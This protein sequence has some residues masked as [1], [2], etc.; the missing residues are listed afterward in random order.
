MSDI[1][2][3]PARALSRRNVASRIAFYYAA[4]FAA[5]GIY[6]PYWGPWLQSNGIAPSEITLL[7]AV[8]TGM[9]LFAN[10]LSGRFADL[11][12]YRKATVVVL[13]FATMIAFF[14][15]GFVEGFL[16]IFIVTVISSIPWGPLVPL[17]DNLALL[18]VRQ[19]GMDY[20]RVRIWGSVAFIVAA[21]AMGGVLKF[22]PDTVIFYGMMVTF[23][24]AS[25]ASV[26]LPNTKARGEPPVREGLLRSLI[27]EPQFRLFVIAA[28]L[29]QSS[30]AI[31]YSLA[32]IEWRRLGFSNEIIGW[33]WAE[34]V[35][36]EIGL[37]MIGYRLV[38]SGGALGLMFIGALC[39]VVRWGGMAVTDDLAA[40]VL[41]QLLHAG[42]FAVAHL[43][44]MHFIAQTVPETKSAAAQNLYAA[45]VTGVA[46]MLGFL[47]AGPLY[48]A[49]QAEA[50]LVMAG[51]SAC[52]GALV[53]LLNKRTRM[54]HWGPQTAA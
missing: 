39:G 46:L 6:L 1:T 43:G 38:R 16:A 36:V 9:K 19:M 34:G 28:A 11:T 3:A 30:H 37:F 4:I 52:G 5:V 12:N 31:Y 49:F 53:W 23:V 17:V 51:L 7:F 2:K 18:N 22:F 24:L 45:T 44:A 33:M 14:A 29:L 21:W 25:I 42:T 26:M 54:I 35:I 10:P 48:E 20:A 27:K 32:T 8:A 41:L 47:A 15:F 40:H 13:T 50:Y